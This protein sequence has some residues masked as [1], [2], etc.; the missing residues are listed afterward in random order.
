MVKALSKNTFT[1]DGKA[2]K[3]R[4]ADVVLFN[5]SKVTLLTSIYRSVLQIF[6]RYVFLFQRDKPMIQELYYDLIDLFNQFLS[7]F[8]KPDVLAKCT[9]GRK[10]VKLKFDDPSNLFRKKNIFIGR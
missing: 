7:Y 1:P 6:K 5:E 9:T 4:I 3:T 10:I 2:R 8:V